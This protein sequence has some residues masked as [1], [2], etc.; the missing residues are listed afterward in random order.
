[1]MGY[2]ADFNATIY[3]KKSKI[4]AVEKLLEKMKKSERCVFPIFIFDTILMSGKM[5]FIEYY[6][7][8]YDDDGWRKFFDLIKPYT[9][10]G[11]VKFNGEDHE[12]WAYGF[13]K[14][15]W[16][17]RDGRIIYGDSFDAFL[18]DYQNDIPDKLLKELKDW[19]RRL[20]VVENL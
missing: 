16:I 19:K 11:F 14:G 1:M 8:S 9:E 15:K 12:T 20:P 3:I 2:T 13:V 4:K 17:H 18:D 5:E 6:D 7:S 10:E